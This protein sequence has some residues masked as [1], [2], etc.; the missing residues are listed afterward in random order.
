MAHGTADRRTSEA[1]LDERRR[2]STPELVGLAAGG[3]IGSGW[4]FA[5]GRVHEVAGGQALWAWAAGGALMLLVAVVMVELSM[6]AP[7]GGGLVVWPLRACGPLV[8]G[9]VAA[10]VWVSYAINPAAQAATIVRG[11][12]RWWPSLN[13]LYATGRV[14]GATFLAVAV[15]ALIVLLTMLPSRLVI[16]V[17][18]V[19]AAYKVG[20]LVL[21]IVVLSTVA[22][23]HSRL[24]ALVSES[25]VPVHHAPQHSPVHL[26][27]VLAA[28][29]NGA[30]VYAYIG[31]QAPLD[32]AGDVRRRGIG[33]AHRVRIAVYGTVVGT[34]LLYGGL[35]VVYERLW[36][37]GADGAAARDTSPFVLFAEAGHQEWLAVLVLIASFAAPLG[38]GLVFAQALTREVAA[39]SRMHLV[40]RGLQAA[41]RARLRVG[42][43]RIDAYWL[44]PLVNLVVGAAILAAVRGDWDELSTLNSIPILVAY[45]VA[46][47]AL[48]S[49]DLPAF[50]GRRGRVL[51]TAA[52]VA[53]VA[54]TP[55]VLSSGWA[56]VWP[57]ALT[58]TAGTV[59]ILGL[60]WVAE[61]DAPLLNR[62]L[63]RYDARNHLGAVLSWRGPWS[64]AGRRAAV[65]F[66]QVTLCCAMLLGCVAVADAFGDRPSVWWSTHA[67]G[68]AVASLWF[69]LLVSS[70]RAYQ[71]ERQQEDRPRMPSG[72][73]VPTW[74]SAQQG[75]RAG[76]R[77]FRGAPRQESD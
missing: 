70:S 60:P 1:D 74:R 62:L 6:A 68:V 23:D 55:V 17:S 63:W 35:Q 36:P 69:A 20:V 41:R 71:R 18:M 19:L 75:L 59:L 65:P 50:A 7:S 14:S 3:T 22:V 26:V 32:F 52:Y 8:A 11:L 53:S 51:R 40:H 61:K 13:S 21:I 43:L 34:S 29:T 2:L 49:V 45:A 77:L 39:L 56:Q 33:E 5:A 16:R 42:R 73:D 58:V 44:I 72:R 66:V 9:V 10:A 15:M 48:A 64:P 4:L 28:L 47:V 24:A 12:A 38:S 30:V 37:T 25:Q 31:F 54:C 76:S 67:A 46:C 27:G 57:A